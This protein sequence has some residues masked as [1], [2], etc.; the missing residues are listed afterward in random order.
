MQ[1]RCPCGGILPDVTDNLSYKAYFIADQ[2]RGDY[3]DAIE[4]AI[5][6]PGETEQERRSAFGRVRRFICEVYRPAWVCR[7]CGRLFIYDG[8]D[9]LQQFI[10]ASE[11]GSRDLF[12][13][14]RAESAVRE[15]DAAPDRGRGPGE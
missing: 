13:S 11:E 9:R 8:R 7:N 1:I 5:L 12:R 6:R 15:P 2:D 14:C 10:P 4:A 3:W